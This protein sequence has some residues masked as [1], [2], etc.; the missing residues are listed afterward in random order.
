MLRDGYKLG[1][2]HEPDEE[3]DKSKCVPPYYQCVVAAEMDW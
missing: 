1:M 2:V 3:K